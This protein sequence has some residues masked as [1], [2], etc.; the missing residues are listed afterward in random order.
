MCI[1]S[2]PFIR[3][4]TAS[5][6]AWRTPRARVAPSGCWPDGCRLAATAR[7]VLA[8]ARDAHGKKALARMDWSAARDGFA[9]F[10]AANRAELAA[11][12]VE[13][14][15]GPVVSLLP[16]V[17]HG[18]S[19]EG[20]TRTISYDGATVL[21]RD[22]KG[23]RYLERL[24]ADPNREFHVLDLLAV[25]RGPLPTTAR[26]TDPGAGISDGGHA[27]FHLDAE[28]RAAYRRRLIDIDADI[29][30]ATAM[31]DTSPDLCAT[32]WRGSPSIIGASANI[33]ARQSAPAPTARASPTPGSPSD[34][35]SGAHECT[36]KSMGPWMGRLSRPD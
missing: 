5:E 25:E 10:G 35:T 21:M 20:D 29:E 1:M 33:C 17:P 31:N 13:Q 16:P 28:A 30:D 18:F 9:A 26:T 36:A 11:N 34:G 22:L 7:T 6:P 4:R 32:P 8:E 2:S 14:G 23:L 3:E 15:L 19:C 27:G 24:L 12:R